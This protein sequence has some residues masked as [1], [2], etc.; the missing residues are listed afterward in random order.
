MG[1][2]GFDCTTGRELRTVAS[3]FNRN[4]SRP[5]QIMPNEVMP[6]KVMP[7]DVTH[8]DSAPRQAIGLAPRLLAEAVRVHEEARGAPLHEPSADERACASAGD[9]ESRIVERARSLSVAPA[10][11][12]ALVHLR[13]GTQAAFAAALVGAG[14][15][16]LDRRDI[17]LR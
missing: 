17:D 5:P 10:L 16:L 11:Q 1:V 8:P 7:N 3:T 2:K 4:A 13:S 14:Q 12:R 15:L 6:N 9:L